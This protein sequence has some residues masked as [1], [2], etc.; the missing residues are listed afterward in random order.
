MKT[1]DKIVSHDAFWRGNGPSLLFIPQNDGPL[2]DMTDYK[3]R[4]NDPCLMWEGE[5]DRSRSAVDWPTDGIPAIRPNL[6]VIVVPALGGQDFEVTAESM[7]WPGHPMSFEEICSIRSKDMTSSPV[8]ALLEG[9]Y[10]YND[11][12]AD[13]EIKAYMADNQG[14]FDIAHLLYGDDIFYSLMDP[15]KAGEVKEIMEVSLDLFL[16]AS[17][18]MKKF[19]HESDGT[20]IHGH[21]TPQGLYFPQ[22]GIRISEDTATLLSPEMI[23]ETILPYVERSVE[24]FG[25]AFLHY[26]GLHPTIF[27]QL[28]G[29]S[30]IKAVDLG[31]PEKYDLE[32]LLKRCAQTDTVFYCR[33]PGQEGEH[34]RDYTLRIGRMVAE[35][36]A[37]VVMRP[38]IVPPTREECEEMLGIWHEL[39]D[40][41]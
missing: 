28:T 7:P 12:H 32:Y 5:M 35:T 15:D 40:V 37:R 38:L 14:V 41:H 2:Y 22:A 25:G 19:N 3:S 20:M 39:T 24:P 23:E 21:G 33:I 11:L 29:L 31:N 18:A 17:W 13:P 34:W 26:C 16:R 4:F 1:A 30:C 6:G 36:G 27:D 8:Y 10:R 9:F